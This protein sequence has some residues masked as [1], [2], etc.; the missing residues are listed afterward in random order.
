MEPIGTGHQLALRMAA[1]FPR[2]DWI[3]PLVARTGLS[4][5]T[6]EWHLHEETELPADILAVAAEL[7][8]SPERDREEGSVGDNLL[9]EDDLPSR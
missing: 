9:T 8:S 4:R 1:R 7:L 2:E 6:I 3:A 5:Q